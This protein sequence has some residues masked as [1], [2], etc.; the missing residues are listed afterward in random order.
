MGTVTI[1]IPEFASTRNPDF[2]RCLSSV[3]TRH[4]HFVLDS[5]HDGDSSQY[6]T[7]VKLK[8]MEMNYLIFLNTSHFKGLLL[9]TFVNLVSH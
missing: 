1:L 6:F 8:K 4:G 3:A 9:E 2:V 7:L 5:D